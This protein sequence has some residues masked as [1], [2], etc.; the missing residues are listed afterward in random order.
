[1]LHK[2]R[3]AEIRHERGITQAKLALDIGISRTALSKIE[4]NLAIPNGDTLLKI[5]KAL[6]VKV[7][8]IF[9]L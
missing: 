8:T 7:E 9:L 1:M 4:G 6:N 2:N 3:V 5:A